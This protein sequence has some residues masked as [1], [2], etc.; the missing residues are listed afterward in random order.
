MIL[1]VLLIVFIC[2]S[3]NHLGLIEAIEKVA[4]AK[5]P[6]LNCCKCS[7]FWATFF[8]LAICHSSIGPICVMAISFLSCFFAI[9]LELSMGILDTL[10][11]VAYERIFNET[12]VSKADRNKGNTE[13][14][15]KSDTETK[16]S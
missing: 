10:Y 6:I 2:T 13:T 11:N 4:G 16:V 8:Y 3:M 5:L 9:W 14:D 12:T 1:K 7:S 15:D